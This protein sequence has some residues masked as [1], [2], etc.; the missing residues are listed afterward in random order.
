MKRRHFMGTALAGAM[1][2]LAPASAPAAAAAGG[3]RDSMLGLLQRMAEP[4][5]A[6]MAKG[7]LKKRFA[8]S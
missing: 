8:L 4:V 1:A 7:E 2:G 6:A 3:D 5:L